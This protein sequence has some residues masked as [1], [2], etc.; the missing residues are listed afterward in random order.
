MPFPLLPLFQDHLARAFH[1]PG[2]FALRMVVLGPVM[3][4]IFPLVRDAVSKRSVDSDAVPKIYSFS[5]K[6]W[7]S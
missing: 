6:K 4:E 3:H 5:P 2:I 7:R 1:P